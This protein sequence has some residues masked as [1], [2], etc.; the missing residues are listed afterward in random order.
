MSRCSS[1]R[2]I[3]RRVTAWATVAS[4]AVGCGKKETSPETRPP[5]APTTTASSSATTTVPKSQR[6]VP[7]VSATPPAAFD[8]A[9]GVSLVNNQAAGCTGSAQAGWLQVK[10]NSANET[11]GLLLKA[12]IVEGDTAQTAGAVTNVAPGADGGLKFVLPWQPKKRG[13]ARIEWT[14]G[15][16]ELKTQGSSGGFRRVLPTAQNE[17]CASLSRQHAERLATIRKS[18]SGPVRAS[19]IRKFPKLGECE[20]VGNDAWVLEVKE[21]RAVGDGVKREV[22]LML[23]VVHVAVD[24]ALAKVAWG[25]LRFAPGQLAIPKVS[26]F[27]YDDDKS[28]EVILRHD[29]LAR[30]EGATTPLPKLPSVFT[31]KGKRVS[32]YGAAG[33]RVTGSV[34][35]ENLEPDQRPD[36]GDY[37]PF[38]GWLGL[39]CGAGRCPER[40]LGPRFYERSLIDGTFDG[41]APEVS[42][43]LQSACSRS[44]GALVADVETVGGKTR[45]AL[46]VACARVRGETTDV[47]MASLDR[48]KSRICGAETQC[49]LYSL[50]STW[51]KAEPPLKLVLP[52]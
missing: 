40:V 38:I 32:P 17:A 37:G 13:L 4:L 9:K 8:D 15:V 26:L 45:T 50:L 42:A 31:Y 16:F 34:M 30:A 29:V 2:E 14:D 10:C 49:Q 24:G 43:A 28:A 46:N 5:A 1:A 6:E 48:E 41:A 52:R 12:E 20:A 36:I 18:E 51:A 22:S 33:L 3:T 25:P 21:L 7:E 39:N 23:N 35:A 19:D 27:D 47:I 11:G 44:R